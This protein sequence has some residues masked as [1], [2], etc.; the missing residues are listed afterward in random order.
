[1]F[2]WLAEL[3]TAYPYAAVGLV[4]ILCGIGLPLPEEL[5]LIAAGYTC[6]QGVADVVPMIVTCVVAILGG[7]FIPFYLGHAFGARLL[8]IRW[9]RIVVHKRRLATFDDWFR[10]RGDL[11][12]FLARFIAGLRVVAYFTAGTMK[13]SWK[14]FLLLDLA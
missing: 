3:F 1:M 9:M 7:D 6:Y 5:V 2:E 14:R 8:R 12:I 11:V 10:R 13:M 4:I